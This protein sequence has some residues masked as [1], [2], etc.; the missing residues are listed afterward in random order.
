MKNSNQVRGNG[1]IK[2]AAKQDKTQPGN[3]VAVPDQFEMVVLNRAG[4]G[5]IDTGKGVTLSA[6]EW[7]SLKKDAFARGEGINAWFQRVMNSNIPK[8]NAA[9]DNG[10]TPIEAALGLD[11]DEVRAMELICEWEEESPAEFCRDIVMSRIENSYGELYSDANDDRLPRTVRAR[12]KYF[13]R[14][15]QPI[16]EKLNLATGTQPAANGGAR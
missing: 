9:C 6:T 8:Q 16:V 2:A 7:E 3:A 12:V 14:L 1:S 4:G 11:S 15:V 10:M 5:R 13:H